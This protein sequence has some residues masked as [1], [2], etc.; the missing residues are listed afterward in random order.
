MSRFNGE[1]LRPKIR[2]DEGEVEKY[3]ADHAADFLMPSSLSLLVLTGPSQPAVAKA[4]DRLLE[5]GGSGNLRDLPGVRRQSVNIRPS[6]LPEIWQGE[7]VRLAV[8]KSTRIREE[9]KVFHC[10]ILE[11]RNPARRLSPVEA[12]LRIERDLVERKMEEMFAEWLKLAMDEARISV[13]AQLLPRGRI[14]DEAAPEQE[15]E[16]PKDSEPIL[17]A[18]D[19]ESKGGA[20]PVPGNPS[21]PAPGAPGPRP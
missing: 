1:V 13:A 4:R 9:D 7:I 11:R 21:R 14:R 16:D 20:V 2:L 18:P 8:G 19:E 10:L 17:G 5:G 12:Y 3:Y 15:S 6:L